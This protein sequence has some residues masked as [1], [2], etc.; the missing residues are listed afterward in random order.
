MNKK[1]KLLNDIIFDNPVNEDEILK[2]LLKNRGVDRAD[3]DQFLNPENPIKL[4]LAGLGLSEKVVKKAVGVICN[5]IENGENILVYGDYDVDGI[6]STAIIWG[7]IYKKTK[8]VAPFIPDRNV[9][10]YGFKYASFLK[11]EEKFNVTFGLIVTVDNGITAKDELA[12]ARRRGVAVVV[13]DHH[14]KETVNKQAKDEGPVTVETSRLSASAIA[15][16]VAKRIDTQAD[17]GLAALGLVADC[18]PLLPPVRNFVCHGIERLRKQIN[19]GLGQILK[20]AGIKQEEINSYVLGF[21]LGPRLNSVG[22]LG[23]ATDALRLLVAKSGSD[24]DRYGRIVE[25]HNQ[26]RQETQQ[27]NIKQVESIINPDSKLLF[28]ASSD[29]QTGL[30]GLAAGYLT[31]KFYRPSVVISL[32]K[33]VSKGSARSIPEVNIVEIL[34]HFSGLL[35]EIGGHSM[36][37]G[38]TISTDKVDEFEKKL[39]KFIAKKLEGISLEPKVEAEGVMRLAAVSKNT[40]AAITRLEPFGIGNPEPRFLFRNLKIT[41]IRKVG[42]TGNH[43]KLRLDETDTKQTEKVETDAIAFK[44]GELGDRLKV[45]DLIEVVASLSLNRWQ[46]KE[47]VE[48][49]VAEINGV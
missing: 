20:K 43:L 22:R 35:L 1:L 21:V 14:L 46:G 29:I 17:L 30:I 32:G 41:S 37:A 44:K 13:I 36:A 34:R 24:L 39:E 11:C 23:D 5:A 40:L 33:E 25:E 38:F 18:L 12:K 45:G 7:A 3:F 26:K 31:S 28:Y 10:G 16:V 9:D 49:N 48:L 27:W 19:P 4:K 6:T 2:I 15:W 47:Q 8:K 42:K